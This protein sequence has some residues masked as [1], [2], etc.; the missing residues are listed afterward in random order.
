MQ[1]YRVN[2]GLLIGLLVGGVVAAGS[3]YGIW[4]WQMTSNANAMLDRAKVAEQNGEYLEAAN[5]MQKYLGFRPNDDEARI[6]QAML[7]VEVAR[8]ALDEGEIRDFHQLRSLISNA[9]FK[10]PGEIELREAYV[11]LIGSQPQLEAAFATEQLQNVKV[12]QKQRPDDIELKLR[13]ARCHN[14]LKAPRE[15]VTVLKEVVGYNP[16][17]LQDEPKWED[18]KAL[19]TDNIEAYSMLSRLLLMMDEKDQAMEV[20]Q[21]MVD[22]NPE[23]AKAHLERGIYYTMID[24]GEGSRNDY[25]DEADS[26]LQR[27]YELDPKDTDILRA[28]AD[29]ALRQDD[30]ETARD[31]LQQGL[32]LGTDNMLFY[33]ALAGLERAQG[34]NDAA[35]QQ[36][37]TGLEKVDEGQRPFLLVDKIDLLIDGRHIVEAQDVIKQFEKQVPMK[38]PPVEF[39][40]ARILAVNED[41]WEASRALEDIR[42]QVVDNDRLRIQLDHLLGMAY[43]KC[44]VNEK[45]L[46][47][48]EQLVRENPNNKP[49]RDMRDDLRRRMGRDP[50]ADTEVAG[51]FNQHLSDELKKPE[52]EQ[53]WPAFQ[54][55]LEKWVEDN[56]KSD[57]ERK[58]LE[59][60][61]L[62]SRK[63]YDEARKMLLETYN[64]SKDDRK[65]QRAVVRLV[66]VDPERGPSSAMKL[67]D[68]TVERFGDD[69]Q[70]RLDRA[71]LI[72]A[73]NEED[74]ADQLLALTEDT[75][76]W[77][78]SHQVELWKGVAA[79]LARV[80][81]REEAEE[82]WKQVAELNPGD[83]PAL[84]QVFDLAL[85]RSDD[86]AMREAQKQVLDLV[87]SKKDPNWA[88][89]EA[90]RKFVQYRNNQ[91]NEKLRDEILK[92]VRT[93]LDERPDW[94]APYILRA[95]LAVSERDYLN[96][97]DDY[98]E[99]FKRGRGNALALAQYVRLLAAQ[100]S[101]QEAADQLA[102][103]D[104]NI[105]VAL[106]G[107]QYPEIL[108]QIG[109]Y[110]NAAD[111]AERLGNAGQSNPNIQRWY[112]QF[113]Q[114][115]AGVQTVSDDMRKKWLDKAGEALAD[116]V[117]Q[118][119]DSPAAWL[120]HIRYLLAASARNQLAANELAKRDGSQEE[121]DKLRDAAIAHRR[122]AEAALREAQLVLEEDQQQLLLANCYRDMGRWFDAESIYLLSHEQNPEAEN[123]NQQ[124]IE[125]YLSPQYPLK[126]GLAKARPLINDILRQYAEDPD[127]VD[128][129]IA[130]WAR[131]TAAKILAASGDYQSLLESEKLLA[132]NAVNNTLAVED[133]LLMATILSQRPEPLSRNKAIKLLEE[134]QAQQRLSPELDLTLAQLYFKTDNWAKCNS[135]MQTVLTRYPN[136][137]AVRREYI[138]M[139]LERGG[140]SDL[141]MAEAQLAA[142]VKIAPTSPA[143]YELQSLVYTE[144]GDKNKA[145]QALRKMLPEDMNKLD[146]QDYMLLTRVATL[147][148]N[149]DDTE[150]AEKLL[151]IVINRPDA[152][153]ANQLQFIQ[154]IGIYRN[155]DEAF[156]MLDKVANDS[157]L[158]AVAEVGMNIVRAKRNEIG[159][160]YDETID[161]WLSTA[162]RDDP[163]SINVAKA[164]A[165][166]RDIEGRY[167]DAAAIYRKLLK[168][169]DLTGGNKAAV[170]NNL[171]YMIALGAAEPQSPNEADMLLQEAID[172]LG[173]R[174][175]I[176]DTRATIWIGRGEFQAAV[177]DMELAVTDGP[178][179]SKYFHK[180]QAHMGLGQKTQALAAWEKAEDLG[181]TRESLGRL[182]A[183]QYDKLAK[184]IEDLRGRGNR[185]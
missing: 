91:D 143:T 20:E 185:L 22:L 60:Q 147:L 130:A 72:I 28:L 177:D 4:R 43:I 11:D 54:R 138:R 19:A 47:I 39:Q 76:G 83:L 116:A 21:H 44:G 29:R 92:L 66:A 142:L 150:N 123:V 152:T 154:F 125:F 129:G 109:D 118:G 146:T 149:L 135:H 81:K 136:S 42:P 94:S 183:D 120:P 6:K 1:R 80:G 18:D 98:R 181:L 27:A 171:A 34:D 70:L 82:A 68:R 174:S 99:G 64:A 45:A 55:Y 166:L 126:D 151:K 90:A 117:E 107:Q 97:L 89:T 103:V 2:Y 84:M 144:T 104:E 155:V 85:A 13:E 108:F 40:K 31:Y 93:A 3:V 159:D 175:D 50:I 180:A 33:R 78:R 145:K 172:I 124:L 148:I 182:E 38:Y 23:S 160:K 57:V 74:M 128:T 127:S 41:W 139:L 88:F 49:A 133:K 141:A 96:A 51:N 184:Q 163:L 156:E 53:N 71:D 102:D 164:E 161:G 63:K 30:Y 14:Y 65:V 112:G 100:G 75:E 7:W 153:L 169:S 173:P 179:A 165:S 101:F 121:I 167:E 176:L 61:V 37:E 10:Y 79:R 26:D 114:R 134:V 115:L 24:Q 35:L 12:L 36:I 15:A 113:M 122:E 168:N 111:A 32:E 105:K 140:R 110:S 8:E 69:W 56:N 46:E 73:L 162:R 131:R 58:L 119:G 87:G 67:L 9:L 59:I 62:V 48:F 170:L 25:G 77:D 95:S 17:A 178:T 86:D 137:F 132:S 52:E 16:D 106:L 157:N 158:V 5:E